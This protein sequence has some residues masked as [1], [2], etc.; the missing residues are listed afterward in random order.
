MKLL[1]GEVVK[2]AKSPVLI[3]DYSVSEVYASRPAQRIFGHT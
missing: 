1:I 3:T 2:F